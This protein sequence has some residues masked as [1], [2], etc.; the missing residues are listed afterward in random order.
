MGSLF[1]S[2]EMTLVQLFVQAEAAHASVSELGESDII[3]FR[4][5]RPI[6]F[7]QLYQC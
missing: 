7:V 1:R 2:Q 4:D 5:V 6:L 3:Q